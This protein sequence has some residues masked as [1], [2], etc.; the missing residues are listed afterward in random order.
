VREQEM[1][2]VLRRRPD[3]T[4]ILDVQGENGAE[5]DMPPAPGSPLYDLRNVVL[6]PHIAGSQRGECR[7]LG[8]CMVEEFD[9]YVQK[10]L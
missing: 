5:P 4:A 8:R 9:R 3:L 10:C 2:D 1:I 6:T 7:R